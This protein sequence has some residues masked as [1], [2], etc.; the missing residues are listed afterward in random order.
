MHN[1]MYRSDSGNLHREG[2]PAID[3][4][5]LKQYWWMGKLH[6]SRGPAVITSAAE[7]YYWRGIFVETSLWERMHSMTAQEI[8]A[9]KNVELRRVIIERCGASKLVEAATLL[10]EQHPQDVPRP[11]RLY[12]VE[13]EEDEPMVF[14]ELVNSSKEPDGTHKDYYLRVP[15]DTKTVKDGIGW[16]FDVA[17]GAYSFAY[18]S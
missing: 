1:Y 13:L 4:P 10:D 15:P 6:N 9:E 2:L 3:L 8:L 5:D 11:N 12:K 16:S 17:D 7:M 18:E 14:L